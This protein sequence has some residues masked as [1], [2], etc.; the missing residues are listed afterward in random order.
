MPAK[1]GLNENYGREILELHTLGVDGG[2]TQKTSRKSPAASPA[3]VW[4]GHLAFQFRPVRHDNGAKIVLGVTIPAGG[5]IEDGEKV[6]DLLA[7]HPSTARFISRKLCQ[8]F[9]SR[10]TPARE[11]VDPR[12]TCLSR[13][14]AIS[15]GLWNRLSPVRSSSP[16]RLFEQRSSRPLSTQF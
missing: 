10:L 11:L 9:V 16:R 15:A 8:R 4:P 3:G 13:A 12:P 6:L 2:Y 5:G 14:T 7:R 1:E